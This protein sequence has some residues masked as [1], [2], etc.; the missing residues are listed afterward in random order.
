MKFLSKNRNYEKVN[1]N[2]EDRVFRIEKYESKKIVGGMVVTICGIILI[3]YTA[4][5]EEQTLTN[6]MIFWGISIILIIIGA[7]IVGT[8][9]NIRKK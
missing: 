4:L 8:E 9:L 6:A 3:I 2:N 1:K 7:Y 5:I